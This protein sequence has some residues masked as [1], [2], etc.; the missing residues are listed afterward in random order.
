M[1]FLSESQ[2][3]ACLRMK[4][5][6]TVNRKALIALASGDTQVPSRLSLLY[7][8]NETGAQDC[9]LFKPAALR[10]E[11]MGCKIISLRRNNH[12]KGLP[13]APATIFSL[14]AS[15]GQVQAVLAGTY[16]TAARTA[17]GSALA[18]QLAFQNRMLNHLVVFGAGMQAE[19]HVDAIY[20][21]LGQATIPKV[22]IV[23]RSQDRAATLKDT[24]LGHQYIRVDDIDIVELENHSKVSEAVSTAD[25]IATTTNTSTPLLTTDLPIPQGCHINGIGS[26][27]LQMTEV[28][29]AD[30][31]RVWIDTPDARTTVG[32]LANLKDNHPVELLGKLL[33][34]EAK[35]TEDTTFP[36]TFYKAV[37]TAIQ[38]VLTA[39]MVVQRARE[40]GLGTEVDMS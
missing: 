6:L 29:I 18:T 39:N 10:D 31:C 35:T 5:C 27:T 9:S 7:G 15:T 33:S 4:D 12:T 19:A 2:V 16:L 26:Y 30:Q 24:L 20:T 11:Q 28:G 37:G 21:T 25:C 23:N 13:L 38:D 22:T 40:L 1:L 3:R 8:T 36:F 34:G 32:D 17:A 14:D